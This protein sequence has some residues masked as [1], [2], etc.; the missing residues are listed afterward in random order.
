VAARADVFEAYPAAAIWVSVRS[1]RIRAGLLLGTCAA[2]LTLARIDPGTN[3]LVGK[4]LLVG[5]GLT[6]VTI[7][8]GAI[9][10]ASSIDDHVVR[11]AP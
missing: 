5:K 9:W 10:V 8:F 4:P 7:G 2:V 6:D 11:I 3:K 1:V